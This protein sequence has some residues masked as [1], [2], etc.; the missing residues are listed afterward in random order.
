MKRISLLFSIIVSLYAFQEHPPFEEEIS[1][2]FYNLFQKYPKEKL[3]LHTDKDIYIAGDTV[4]FRS[5]MVNAFTNIPILLSRLIY[6]ELSDK[7]DS[8][9]QRLKFSEWDSTFYGNIN[10]P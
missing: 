7:R 8:V 2:R 6:V 5:Y 10:L 3:Y 4:W 9:I 1:D